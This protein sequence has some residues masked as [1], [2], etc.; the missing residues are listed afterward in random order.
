MKDKQ[1]NKESASASLNKP[2]SNPIENETSKSSSPAMGLLPQRY[3]IKDSDDGRVLTCLEA[4]NISV[5]VKAGLTVS[6]SS[7]YKSSPGTIYLDGVAQCEPFMNLEKQVYNFDHHEGCVRPFTLSTC[8]QVLVMI[9][10]GLDL[11]D[12]DWKVF[13]NDPDL[14]TALAIWLL[15]NHVRVR[16]KDSEDLRLL[17][18][19]VRLEGIIDAHGLEM[20]HLSALSPNFSNTIKK[21]INYL[22]AEEI[23][24]KKNA[25]WEKNDHLEYT[26]KILHKIDRVIYKS[27]ELDDFKE[28][29]EL[30][31]IEI[32]DH[33]I[34]VVIEAE[35]G[36]YE[37]EPYLDRI[38]GESLGLVVLK[39][40]EG[41]YT[42]RRMDP[43]LPLELNDVYEKL[44][45]MDPNVSCRKNGSKW[46]GSDDIGGS[47]RGIATRLTPK[48]IVQACHDASQ[49][50]SFID[51]MI[52][53][54]YALL[55]SGT[56]VGVSTICQ[57][58]FSSHFS[59]DEST[60][61]NLLLMSDLAFFI[62]LAL[63][64]ALG[65]IIVTRAR[66]WQFGIRIPTG[67]IWWFLLPIVILAAFA[68]GV[69]VPQQIFS[70]SGFDKELI[71]TIFTIPLATEL[72]FRSLSHG[73]L[74]KEASIQSCRSEWF[75]SYPNVASAFLYAAFIVY[76]VLFP[77]LLHGVLQTKVFVTCLFGA[78]AFG[79]AVGFVREKSHSVLP[80]IIF[81]VIAIT[82]FIFLNLI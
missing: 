77:S 31:R 59:P 19:L 18:A 20:T 28:L 68:K 60:R 63:F 4:P 11:R 32:S 58:Y 41:I 7:A 46:G 49:K 38:Y 14:D 35:L 73:I 76:L 51:N 40:G 57:T 24:L 17:Y 81:H 10:K 45:S 25:I 70:I 79:L 47:P 15:F 62:A 82:I 30:A 3:K 69:Y 80:G 36:I 74:A 55:L 66:W 27:H 71:F 2:A 50:S 5:Y 67:K 42:L 8:E 44:N 23:D 48:E 21:V 64:T 12:R 1:K 75:F 72:L 43:F 53:F 33:R 54:F 34:A 22:R 52:N 9:F 13:A 78:F 61:T 16:Q 56:I 39:K 26:G 6:A 65:L 37:L 29:N